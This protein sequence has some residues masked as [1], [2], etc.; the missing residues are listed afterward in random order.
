MSIPVNCPTCEGT[1]KV[2][3]EADSWE[4]GDGPEIDCPFCE[5][6]GVDEESP[7]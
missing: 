3:N 5:G 1:G 4:E 7:A 2:P 6:T